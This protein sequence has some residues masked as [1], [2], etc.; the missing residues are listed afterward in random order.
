MTNNQF[1]PKGTTQEQYAN[2]F[3]V[4]QTE[5]PKIQ[6]VPTYSTIK[7]IQNAVEVNLINMHNNRD[8]TYGKLHLITNTALAVLPN[9][10]PAPVVPS[11]NQGPPSIWN[12]NVEVRVR[13]NQLLQL[14][15][16]AKQVAV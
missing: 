15:Y 3:K 9:R 12:A 11:T 16:R 7:P 4:K 1:D 5:V 10:P 13:E 2:E 6:G 14:C 8:P